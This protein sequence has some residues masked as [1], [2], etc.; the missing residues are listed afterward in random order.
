MYESAL[1]MKAYHR[2][3]SYLFTGFVGFSY[4][5]LLTRSG[6]FGPISKAIAV[7][8]VLLIYYSL[9]QNLQGKGRKES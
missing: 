2:S 6:E 9:Y 5:G 1:G 3:V 8:A 7:P 4:M